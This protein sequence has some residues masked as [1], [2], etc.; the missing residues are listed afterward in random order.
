MFVKFVQ[1]VGCKGVL[2]KC[3]PV[4]DVGGGGGGLGLFPNV[5]SAVE[6]TPN[7]TMKTANSMVKLPHCVNLL[8]GSIL[9]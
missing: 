7:N 9:K 8:S 2:S 6:L 4:F 3:K 1:N 5:V